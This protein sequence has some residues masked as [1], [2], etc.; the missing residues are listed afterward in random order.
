MRNKTAYAIRKGIYMKKSFCLALAAI[1]LVNMLSVISF[2]ESG[3]ENAVTLHAE[4]A[5][6]DT[7]GKMQMNRMK[8]STEYGIGGRNAND[9]SG[10]FTVTDIGSSSDFYTNTYVSQSLAANDITVFG[11]RFSQC[12]R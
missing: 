8:S 12:N 9:A 5:D 6:E 3:A 1:M 11:F 2:A 7:L 4:Y 10:K